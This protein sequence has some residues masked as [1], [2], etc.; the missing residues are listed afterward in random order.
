MSR[1]KPTVLLQHSNKTTYKMDL[2]TPRFG[3]LRKQHE[4][5]IGQITRERQRL[6]DQRNLLI[7]NLKIK[8]IL[9]G[10]FCHLHLFIEY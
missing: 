7:K 9:N 1:P 3:K 10:Y 2:Y 6:R 4:V 5:L 8:K